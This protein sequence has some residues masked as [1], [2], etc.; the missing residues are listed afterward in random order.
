[1]AFQKQSYNTGANARV[2]T[3]EPIRD[4]R[5]LIR[6]DNRFREL[7][8]EKY[9]VL[10]KFGCYSG[11]RASDI[12]NFKA[13][14]LYKQDFCAIREI[15]TGKT[16]RFPINHFAQ[17]VINEYVEKFK[18]PM[19][20]YLFGGRGDRE[21]DRSQAYRQINQVCADLG[22]IANVGTH[23]MRKT[24][25]YH[26]YRKGTPIAVLMQIFNHSSPDV[27]LRYIGVTQDEINNVYWNLDLEHPT[28]DIYDIA[29]SVNGSNRT[30]IKKVTKFCEMYLKLFTEKGTYAPF[31]KMI[32]EL[33]GITPAAK[34]N[35]NYEPKKKEKLE[36][37]G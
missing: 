30:R 18:I 20:A 33:I 8:M 36:L 26:A 35:R 16:K 17:K 3:V 37:I 15:K 13:K 32:L 10:F 11:L 21:L 9:A 2:A 34:E 28:M 1:M 5:D 25:G 19:D 12:L 29:A 24:F 27:T 6:I 14:D 31:A 7:G 4:I 23:T 22:I